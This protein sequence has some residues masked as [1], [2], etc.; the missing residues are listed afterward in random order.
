MISGK[1]RGKI[2]KVL[3]VLRDREKVVVEKVNVVKKHKKK[4]GDQKDPGGIIEVESPID[5]SNV[6]LVCPSC[7]KPT[8][9]EFNVKDD[10][11]Q[12]ICKKCNSTIDK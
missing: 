8:R 4:T 12:R 7:D 6:M 9:S 5:I 11:K 2:G 1:Y 3:S 10:K